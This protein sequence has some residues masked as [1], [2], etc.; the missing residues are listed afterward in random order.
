MTI[1]ELITRLQEYPEETHVRFTADMGSID[2]D[3]PV[4]MPGSASGKPVVWIDID[5]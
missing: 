5:G 3:E 2:T 1:K 4:I